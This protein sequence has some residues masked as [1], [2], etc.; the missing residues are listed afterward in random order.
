MCENTHVMWAVTKYLTYFQ[1]EQTPPLPVDTD[2]TQLN[3][4]VYFK[5]SNTM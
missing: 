5:Y 2:L 1:Y 3:I 4:F